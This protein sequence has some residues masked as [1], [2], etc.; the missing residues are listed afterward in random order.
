MGSRKRNPGQ[1]HAGS[2]RD[3][4]I[5]LE[6]IVFQTVVERGEGQHRLLLKR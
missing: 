4:R 1:R 5:A 6:R 3:Q 2:A